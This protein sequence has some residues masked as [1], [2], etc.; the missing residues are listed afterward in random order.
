MRL[1]VALVTLLL[2]AAPV[3]AGEPV[4]SLPVDCDLGTTCYIQHYVDRDPG[5]GTVDYDCGTVTYDGHKG[6][7]IALPTVAD[8]RHGV[9]VLAAAS[10]IVAATRDGMA[11]VEYSARDAERVGGRECGNGVLIRHGDGWETQYCHMRQGSVV[12]H[13]G[14]RVT[15]GDTL[16]LVGMSGKAQFPHLHLSVRH[17]GQVIDPFDPDP[18]AACGSTGRTLWAAPPAYEPAN[19]VD[20]GF[21]AGVPAYDDV[22]AGIAAQQVLSSDAPALVLF[23]FAANGRA[24]DVIRLIFDGPDGIHFAQEGTLKKNQA[25][26]FRAAG[27][28]RHGAGWPAGDYFGSVSLSRNGTEIARRTANLTIIQN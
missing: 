9:R 24:G 2:P 14:D 7:D 3:A 8:M 26:F 17:D 16:G 27:K 20:A 4:L 1:A 12:V 21:A 28:R 22:K 5:P 11:D 23:G 18:S 15:R 10:G 19:M 13:K 25:Q 6:T